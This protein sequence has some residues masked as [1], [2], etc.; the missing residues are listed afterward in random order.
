MCVLNHMEAEAFTSSCLAAWPTIWLYWLPFHSMCTTCRRGLDYSFAAPPEFDI[1]A[2]PVG[3]C[4]LPTY[5]KTNRGRQNVKQ[6]R[7]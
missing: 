4:A 6:R 7:Y 2:S 1:Q 5:Y 3:E